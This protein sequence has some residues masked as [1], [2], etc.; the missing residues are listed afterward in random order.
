MFLQTTFII[1]LTMRWAEHSTAPC[2]FSKRSVYRPVSSICE[3]KIFKWSTLPMTVICVCFDSFSRRPSRFQATS[4]MSFSSSTF[5]KV[6]WK[7]ATSPRLIF[8]SSSL[9]SNSGAVSKEKIYLFINWLFYS[10][11]HCVQ[12][13]KLFLCMIVRYDKSKSNKF[14]NSNQLSP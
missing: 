4:G 13:I 1:P 9:F 2:W 6:A 10:A 12:Y 11:F 8:I 3:F 5:V 14:G 7:W